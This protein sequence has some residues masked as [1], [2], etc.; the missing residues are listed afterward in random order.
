MVRLVF[1]GPSF[2]RSVGFLGISDGWINGSVVPRNYGTRRTES[3]PRIACPVNVRPSSTATAASPV[4]AS[5]VVS[6]CGT[7]SSLPSPFTSWMEARYLPL[8]VTAWSAG[9]T[10]KL[11]ARSCTLPYRRIVF[12][13]ASPSPSPLGLAGAPP[14]GNRRYRRLKICATV[15]RSICRQSHGL[16]SILTGALASVTVATLTVAASKSALLRI[17]TGIAPFEP[18]LIA[19]GYVP[20]LM[21][22]A[23][24]IT[25][26]D[27]F[28]TRPAN[29][30][31]R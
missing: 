9:W 31:I 3:V 8:P 18:R 16:H 12:C 20:G 10:T 2:L 28:R 7:R 23:A 15:L 17:A 25:E 27:T 19:L 1:M 4:N 26:G 21:S 6:T 30:P 14:I 22:I 29:S 5:A 13:G 11:V 24:V